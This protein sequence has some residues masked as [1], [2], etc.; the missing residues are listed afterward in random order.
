MFRI[1]EK[2]YLAPQ[3]NYA[4]IEAPLVASKAEAGQ[5]VI[6]RAT[7]KGERIPLTI[8]DY[9]RKNGTITIVFQEIGKSTKQLGLLKKGDYILDFLGPQGNPTEIEN[10]GN[11]VL[12]GGGIGIAPIYPLA[13]K[14]KEYK[15]NVTSIIGYRTKD[16]VFWE[17]KMRNV[18]DSFIIGTNDGSYGKKG[19]VT[20]M[21]KEL[22]DEKKKIDRIFAIGPA[23][24]MKAVSELTKEYNI[25]TIVSLNS[26]MVCGMGMC[27]ACRVTIDKKTKFTCMD[28]P[29]FDGHLVDFDELMKRLAT[30]KENEK[31]CLEGFEREC[32]N[33]NK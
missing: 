21:L 8:A 27:G 16:Y 2:Y 1:L 6:V 22:L 28:G 4:L 12:V 5:F 20:D 19:L 9:D 10:F 25:K 11:V 3:I 7:E 18:S 13:R 30:Y 26:L 15:N 29:D 32:R 17:E 33:D 24:M 31:R 23:I 14:L